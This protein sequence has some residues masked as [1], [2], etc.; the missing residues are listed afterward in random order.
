VPCPCGLAVEQPWR[1][2]DTVWSPASVVGGVVV[3]ALGVISLVSFNPLFGGVLLGV[4][5]VAIVVAAV[6]QARRGHRGWC[7]LRR[8]VWFGVAAPGAPVRL[9][10]N[11]P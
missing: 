10:V 5:G 2:R 8:A 7:L 4:F 1:D 11:S 3:I 6:V 9:I